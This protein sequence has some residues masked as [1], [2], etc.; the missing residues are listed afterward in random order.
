MT[1]P[2]L[3][4]FGPF[5]FDRESG[6]LR[7]HG[8]R[9]RLPDQ[10]RRVLELLLDHHGEI[11]TREEIRQQLWAADTFVD[12]DAGLSS[13]VRKL[14]DALGDS[15][16]HPRYIETVPRRGYRFIATAATMPASA[17]RASAGTAAPAPRR[18]AW[19]AAAIA[20]S[21]GAMVFAE[22]KSRPRMSPEAND[23]FLKGVAAAGRENVSGFRAAVAYFEEATRKQPTFALAYAR[24][25]QAQMQLVY[26]GQFAPRDI[27]PRADLAVRQALALDD[28]IALAHR[29]RAQILH[30]YY[31]QWEAGDRE[32]RRARQLDGT[33]TVAHPPQATAALSEGR[34]DEAIA[35][36]ERARA[37]DPLAPQAALNLGATLRAAGQF[38][39][40][41]S[42]FRAA[43][44]LNP[45]MA[46]GYFQLG[47][48]YVLME[49]WPDAIEAIG[50]ALEITPDNSRFL[51]Y[52][53]FAFAK[54]GRADQ[55]RNVLERLRARAGTQYVSSFGVALILDA[56][57]ER[58]AAAA[59][60]SRAF[61]D[62]ALELSQWRQYPPFQ[63]FQA[64]PRFQ[65][66]TRRAG[67]IP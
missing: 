12:F 22:I 26:T 50:R 8:M 44:A 54:A 62:H 46:R 33:S 39:R 17:P 6:E 56:L 55:A 9:V 65:V 38:D 35:E 7:K 51:A 52:Q 61:D 31:W 5:E 42:E 15:A 40:A 45:Q 53:G 27:A 1:L 13:V 58:A 18:A 34:F 30:D 25:A 64:D 59:A 43:L 16:D 48:T 19:M 47:I 2:Q 3:L 29:T 20:V 49:R 41:L 10:P 63:A 21:I 14:R 57:G 24:L 32:L 37:R 36:A 28:S 11:V 60:I 66:L 4:S 23:A 67:R